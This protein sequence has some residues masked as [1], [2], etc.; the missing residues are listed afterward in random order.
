MLSKPPNLYSTHLQGILSNVNYQLTFFRI[1][2]AKLPAYVSLIATIA[3]QLHISNDSAY[4]GLRGEK[5]LTIFELHTLAAHVGI[6]INEF[7][8]HL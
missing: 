6:S 7:F 2:K 8:G 1:I 3:K 4:H 5:T